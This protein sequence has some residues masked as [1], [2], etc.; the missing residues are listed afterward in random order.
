M[1]NFECIMKLN[2]STG[3]D[4]LG[5]KSKRFDFALGGKMINGEFLVEVFDTKQRF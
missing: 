1:I 2:F 3:S 4:S 5:Q